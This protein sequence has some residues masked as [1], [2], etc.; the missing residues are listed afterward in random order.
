M[1]LVSKKPA[2]DDTQTKR[3]PLTT[4]SKLKDE[5]KKER[6][7]AQ[8]ARRA[9]LAKQWDNDRKLIASN[10]NDAKWLDAFIRDHKRQAHDIR[11][12]QFQMII[13]PYEYAILQR[14]LLQDGGF[15]SVREMVITLAERHLKVKW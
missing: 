1:S 7:D 5:L 3:E 9:E 4:R 6:A 10:K 12:G 8:K 15:K 11:T 13:N 2:T 14:A